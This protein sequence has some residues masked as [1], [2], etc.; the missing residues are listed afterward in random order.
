MRRCANVP[1]ALLGLILPAAS[2]AYA[3]PEWTR[4][5]GLDFWNQG[6]E[7]A[8]LRASN[9]AR[10]ELDEQ[11]VHVG[12]RIEATNHIAESLC[13]GRRTL[14]EAVD[15]S[16]AIAETFPDWFAVMRSDYRTNGFVSSTATDRDV[17]TCYLFL[18]IESM[19]WTAEQLGDVSRAVY[20]SDR[21]AELKH[22]VQLQLQQ[23]S[24]VVSSR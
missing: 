13:E 4:S 14:N 21:L 2:I 18:K 12:R 24:Q 8:R 10:R 17:L 20:L 23:S 22:E 11:A 16:S 3:A 1:A 19:R 15:A 9:D 5:A 7:A 6:R